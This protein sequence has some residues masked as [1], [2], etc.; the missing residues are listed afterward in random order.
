M[1]TKE[2]QA[3]A[4]PPGHWLVFDLNQRGD[5]PRVHDAAGRPYPLWSHR[6]TPIPIAAAVVFLRDPAFRVLDEAGVEQT[7][8]PDAENL[9]AAKRRPNL[10][11]G[12]TIAKFEELT[13]TALLARAALRPGGQVFNAKTKR[14]ALI[15]WLKEAPALGE[16]PEHLKARGTGGV[17]DGLGIGGEGM[18]D[19]ATKKLL[20]GG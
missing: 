17:D 10:E 7:P 4:P 9:D 8:L 13:Q 16:L 2:I 15:G 5:A 1:E 19:D 14:E 18:S 20:E 3:E 11:P 6:G 12:E